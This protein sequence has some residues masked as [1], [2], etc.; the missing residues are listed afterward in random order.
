MALTL[1]IRT[2][3]FRPNRIRI[4]E[5]RTIQARRTIGG[6]GAISITQLT[7]SEDL[8]ALLRSLK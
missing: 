6:V 4:L 3:N 5:V 7:A 1:G 8:S 2:Y